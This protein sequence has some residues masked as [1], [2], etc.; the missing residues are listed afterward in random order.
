[1]GVGVWS[2]RV[3][4]VLLYIQN[5][6]YLDIRISVLMEEVHVECWFQL[7]QSYINV[8]N[9]KKP[10]CEQVKNTSTRGYNTLFIHAQLI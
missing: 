4:Q 7:N 10:N 9:N 5:F 2:G 1:M 6:A 8:G 3:R